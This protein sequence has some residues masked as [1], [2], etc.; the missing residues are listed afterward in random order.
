MLEFEISEKNVQNNL[1]PIKGQGIIKMHSDGLANV[2]YAG[3]LRSVLRYYKNLQGWIRK[4]KAGHF[5]G[6]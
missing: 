2:R 5:A 6:I 4:F 3:T 1:G